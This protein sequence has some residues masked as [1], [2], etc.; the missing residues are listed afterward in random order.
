MNSDG[1]SLNQILEQ[2]DFLDVKEIYD[3]TNRVFDTLIGTPAENVRAIYKPKSG[4]APLYDFPRG[5]LFQREHASYLVS[6]ALS[7]DIV[8]TT[9]IRTGPYG[10]GS[11]QEYIDHDSNS[12][13]IE[14]KKTHEYRLQEFAVFD[15]ITNNAD[16][17]GTHFLLDQ[18][19]QIWG[20]DHGLTFSTDYKLRTVVWD[21]IGDSIPDKIIRDLK[22]I[23]ERISTGSSLFSSIN[24]LIDKDELAALKD[25][26][27]LLIDLQIFPF[28]GSGRNVPWPPF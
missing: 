17:K 18:N 12:T 27:S 2:G 22:T 25:R 11:V 3:G 9:T 6:E 26:I 5:T 13:Y 1:L 8:P 19:D 24:Q 14:L 4:E 23:D 28:P 16:R 15:I 10:I 21:F 20:I 7:W